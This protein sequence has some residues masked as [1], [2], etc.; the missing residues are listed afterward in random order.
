MAV[1]VT[2]EVKQVTV[3]PVTKEVT[4]QPVTKQISVTQTAPKTV[5][6][7]KTERVVNVSMTGTPGPQGEKGDP[8]DILESYTM[9]SGEDIISL[10]VVRRMS[11]GLGYH[12]DSDTKSH[13]SSVIG[14]ATQSVSTGGSFTYVARGELTDPSWSW[15][16]TYTDSTHIWV[17]HVSRSRNRIDK[18]VRRHQSTHIARVNHG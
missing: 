1:E 6:V 13:A 2:Q 7:T 14:V 18:H 8:G 15:S 5:S 4:V 10:K 12:A 11:D 3:T 17:H 9:T 16:D